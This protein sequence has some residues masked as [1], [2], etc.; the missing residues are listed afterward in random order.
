MKRSLLAVIIIFCVQWGAEAQVVQ[1]ASKVIDVSSELTPVQYSAQ[2]VLGSEGPSRG[3][4]GAADG[5]KGARGVRAE[6]A[7]ALRRPV[8]PASGG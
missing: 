8:F 2:Q 7:A 3:V 1:W 4:G 6:P 5:I